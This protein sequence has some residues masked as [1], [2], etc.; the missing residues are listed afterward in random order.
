[1]RSAYAY[2]PLC[3]VRI[4]PQWFSG[5]R[6]LWTTVRLQAVCELCVCKLCKSPRP[7]FCSFNHH[8]LG[9]R[10]SWLVERRTCD[11]KVASS[12]PGRSGGG[13]FFSRVNFLCSHL[14]GFFPI[15]VLP[16]WHVKDPGHSAK[17]AG[18]RL[19]L[20]THPPLIQRS[21]RGADYAAVQA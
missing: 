4:S 6:R 5:L 19:H 2:S 16:Q 11:G 21:R 12:S 13:I 17:G 8:I 20:N 10:D 9:S 14:L 7:A 18:G 15:P 1:M 3:Q